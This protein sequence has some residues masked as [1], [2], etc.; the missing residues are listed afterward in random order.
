MPKPVIIITPP[1]RGSRWR[2][3]LPTAY[4]IDHGSIEST[5]RDTVRMVVGILASQHDYEILEHGHGDAPVSMDRW[6]RDGA[7]TEP[8]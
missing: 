3:T 8:R 1:G 4:G 7:P 5:S 2:A 6:W